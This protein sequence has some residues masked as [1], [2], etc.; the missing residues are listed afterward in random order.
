M[1]QKLFQ[2][3]KDDYVHARQTQRDLIKE[4]LKDEV[5][6]NL[7]EYLKAKGIDATFTP[8]KGVAHGKYKNWMWAQIYSRE[9]DVS[10]FVSLQVFD[11]DPKTGNI[12]VLFD[13]LGVLIHE[14][15][16]IPHVVLRYSKS[17]EQLAK[18]SI[19]NTFEELRNLVIDDVLLESANT[20]I[21]L[22]MTEENK[23]D[24]MNHILRQFDLFIASRS[25]N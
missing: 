10:V 23:E 22:P 5:A 4:F 25:K 2:Q 17:E 15:K 21:T 9:I 6:K 11:H 8:T 19:P 12:H 18:P 16:D 3:A 1:T 14:G 24:L 13:Q 20:E 7:Q